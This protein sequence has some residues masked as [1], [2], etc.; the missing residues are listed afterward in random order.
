MV[1]SGPGEGRACTLSIFQ[2]S[3]AM[4]GTFLSF[5]PGRR[6]ASISSMQCVSAQHLAHS[7][8]RSQLRCADSINQ[9]DASW[10]LYSLQRDH[11]P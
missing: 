6:P 2:Y 1:Q 3:L 7:A 5:Q 9:S 8:Q 10:V 4:S 11:D